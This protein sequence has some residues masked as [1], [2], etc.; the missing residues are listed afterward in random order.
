LTWQSGQDII[1]RGNFMSNGR[2]PSTADPSFRP[3]QQDWPVF[4]F[5]KKLGSVGATPVATLFTIGLAQQQAVQFV[6]NNGL[7]QLASL[8]T[9]YWTNGTGALSFFH[10]DYSNMNYISTALDN[11]IAS[12]STAAA[13]QNYLTITS[14]A[15]RQAFGAFELVG[16]PSNMYIFMEEISSSGKTN[17]VDV[18]FPLHP[19]LLYTNS[20]L[21]KLVLAPLYE[22]QES[23]HYPNTYSMHDLGLFPNATGYPAGN[24]E[25]MLLEEC[26]NMVIMTLAYAQLANDTAYLSQHYPKLQ[27]WVGY[28]INDSLIPGYQ[29]ST[30][31]FAGPLANRTNLAPKASL[32]SAP[33]PKSP[34]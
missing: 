3:I 9:S 30:D 17:T 10:N 22:N 26:G 14:L 6:G 34:I 27:Q 23:G 15:L 4:G 24:D 32:A 1:V 5:A 12:D 13:G 28:L 25:Q 19:A 16:T 11:Q 33:W 20:E 8:W 31:D 18:V 21:L 29:V 2:L 7:V